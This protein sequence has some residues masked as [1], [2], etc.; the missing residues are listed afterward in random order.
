MLRGCCGV[1]RG[2]HGGVT[3]EV[4]EW[5]GTALGVLWE[6]YGGVAG[7]LRERYEVA[8]TSMMVAA[9]L[10]GVKSV[11]KFL[12]EDWRFGVSLGLQDK[13][14]AN[15][16]MREKQIERKPKFRRAK[17]EMPPGMARS[18]GTKMIW[19]RNILFRVIPTMTYQD[20]YLDMYSTYSDN[21]SWHI[22][23]HSIWH[24]FWHAVWH[25]IWHSIWHIFLTYILTCYLTSYLAFYLTDI[26][27]Y[28]LA[29]CLTCILTCYLEKAD[30]PLQGGAE[31]KGKDKG[32]VTWQENFLISLLTGLQTETCPNKWITDR[33][34]TCPCLESC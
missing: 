24:I 28:I 34:M 14:L 1:L 18:F 5:Y 7:M 23:R 31:N 4:R 6:C 27:I 2:C 19:K 15:C 13:D 9:S 20:V 21:L 10:L 22:F 25:P 16:D 17:F 12:N 8:C 26:Y 3:G 33:P 30:L 29:F 11:I 32:K